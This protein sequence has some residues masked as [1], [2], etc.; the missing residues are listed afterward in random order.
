MIRVRFAPSPTGYLHLGSLRTALYD[1]L[2]ARKNKGKFTLRIEDTDNQRKVSGA[3]ESLIKVLKQIGLEYDEGPFFDEKNP[4]KIIEKGE[5]GP[6]IQ[7]KRLEIYQQMAK[8]LIDQDKAY[9]CFCTKEDLEESRKKQID[10]CLAAAYDRRCRTLSKEEARQKLEQK[11]PY[12]IRLKVPEIGV[13]K[14]NDLIRGEVEFDLKNID[15]QVLLKSDGFPTYHLAVVVDDYL[16][17]ITHVIR[18]EE[19]L[20]SVPKHL[21][22]YQAFGWELPKFA[23]LPLILNP[24]KSKLSKRQGDVAVEDFLTAGYL[25][26]ALINFIAFLGWNPGTEKEIFSLKELIK[27]FSLEKIQKAGAVFNREKLD[28]MNGCYIRTKKIDELT[29]LCLPYLVRAGLMKEV[30]PDVESG[31]RPSYLQISMERREDL[32]FQVLETKEDVDFKWL[33]KIIVLEQE[34]I[35]KLSEIVEAVKFF[36]SDKLVYDEQILIWK[37]TD[38]QKTKK[39]LLMIKDQIAEIKN[40]NLKEIQLILEKMA[41]QEGTGEIFWPFRVALSGRKNSPP[42]AEMAE[43]LGQEKTLRRIEEAI[44][45][46][47]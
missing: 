7:S 47:A 19:W 30:S 33:K 6:Y 18:G 10:N 43:I 21:L 13:V 14:F 1:F 27:E 4:E 39:C 42:P 32:R 31:S 15:D 38:A 40:F 8:K 23:H 17:K 22:I 29:N 25:P 37:K 46:L 16:M 12:V 41:K 45:K 3:L 34:R 44:D 26:E 5:Y 11:I 2:L 28:W 20:P 36:F 9:Y 24:D 35:K